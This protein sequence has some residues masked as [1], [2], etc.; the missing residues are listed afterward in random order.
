MLR[1]PG[2]EEFLKSYE[3]GSKMILVRRGG[4]RAGQFL[5]LRVHAEGGEKGLILLLEGCEGWGQTMLQVN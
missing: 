2:V 4:N 1:N 5:E 3:E